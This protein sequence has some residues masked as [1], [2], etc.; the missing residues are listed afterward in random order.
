MSTTVYLHRLVD[1]GYTRLEIADALEFADLHPFYWRTQCQRY[2][3]ALSSLM[4]GSA[5]LA[6]GVIVP[7]D[8]LDA[9]TIDEFGSLAQRVEHLTIGR[10]PDALQLVQL[11]RLGA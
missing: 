5:E 11:S 1:A 6:D 10:D 9:W 2:Q 8:D 4:L 7:W 3:V